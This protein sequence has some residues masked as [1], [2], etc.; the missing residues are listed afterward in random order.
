MKYSYFVVCFVNKT[1]K[2]VQ[3]AGLSFFAHF[4]FKFLFLPSFMIELMGE[5]E[6]LYSVEIIT[7]MHNILLNLFASFIVIMAEFS[8]NNGIANGAI[9]ALNAINASLK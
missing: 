8:Q 9:V 7:V 6:C 5:T 1:T 2:I 4:F 3:M